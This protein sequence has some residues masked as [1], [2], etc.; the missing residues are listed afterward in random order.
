M[1]LWALALV[2]WLVTGL[3]VGAAL[4][5]W[6]ESPSVVFDAL[7]FET[8]S[9]FWSANALFGSGPHAFSHGE[10]LTLVLLGG[11][12]LKHAHFRRGCVQERCGC[13]AGS[14]GINGRICSNSTNDDIGRVDGNAKRE[15]N[16]KRG[17][18]GKGKRSKGE[19]GESGDRQVLHQV[20]L[21][22]P[23]MR[24]SSMCRSPLLHFLLP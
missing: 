24:S 16:G 14:K 20:F 5:N 1:P 12:G 10:N 17:S 7:G 6:K 18:K 2:A 23:R 13:A 15:S 11:S 8:L 22:A 21:S 9:D 4:S 19:E 3:Q